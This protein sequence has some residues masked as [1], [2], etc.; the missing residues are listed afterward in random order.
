M[1]QGLLTILCSETRPALGCT[2]PISVAFAAAAAREAVGG[3]LISLSMIMDKDTYKNSISVRTPG[4]PYFGVREPAIVG[5][6]YGNYKKGLEVLDGLPALDE[7]KIA[8]LSKDACKIEIKWDQQWLG[9]YIEVKAVTSCGTGTAIVAQGHDRL[10]LLESNGRVL[11]RDENFDPNDDQFEKKHAIRGYTLS[12]LY[13]FA[14][15][16][17]TEHLGFLRDAL[18]KNQ[19]LAESGLNGRCGAEIGAGLRN[20]LP[21]TALTK[22][23]SLAAAAADARMSGVPLPAVSCAHSGNVGI[24]ASVPLKAIAECKNIPEDK[25]L[26]GIAL[27]YL[28]TIKAKAHIG[29][30]SPVCACAMA[31]SLGVGSA[32]CFMLDGSFQQMEYTIG[33]IIGST[34]GVLCDG[35]KFGCALKLGM[36]VGTAV[37]CALLGLQD[38]HIPIGDGLV[39][40]SAE[41]TLT[42]L[43]DIA[44]EGMLN[45]DEYMSR[46]FIGRGEKRI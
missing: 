40:S 1:D 12:D 15:E 10:V 22:A 20:I 3:E 38:I 29:R 21:D 24:T 9:V 26:R 6:L 7:A 4:T 37:K 19:R 46:K 16:A 5:A 30:L 18:E 43:G 25:L 33:N 45:V 27:S 28:V 8:V 2:G 39:D 23:E 32:V 13:N 35:A 14:K 41:A 11:F 34:G 42:L 31:A 17:E 44:S 36:A